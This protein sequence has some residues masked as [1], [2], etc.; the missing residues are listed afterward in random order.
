MDYSQEV[1]PLAA[2]YSSQPQDHVGVSTENLYDK[3]ELLAIVTKVKKTFVFPWSTKCGIIQ[4]EN[5]NF[6]FTN[7]E[8]NVRDKTVDLPFAGIRTFFFFFFFPAKS[9]KN[10]RIENQQN[11]FFCF[12]K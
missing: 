1:G 9:N 4:N 2:S 10:N 5:H 12:K 3:Q 8:I 11:R 6:L 7:T